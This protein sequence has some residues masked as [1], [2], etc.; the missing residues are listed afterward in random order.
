MRQDCAPTSP[1]APDSIITSLA[2]LLATGYLRHR[3]LQRRTTNLSEFLTVNLE[4]VRSSLLTVPV[5]NAPESS[6]DEE[7]FRGFEC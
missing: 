4:D 2:S 6:I 5:V 1:V 7:V 3:A